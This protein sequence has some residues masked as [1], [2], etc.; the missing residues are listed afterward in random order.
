MSQVTVDYC[1]AGKFLLHD[2]MVQN[3]IVKCTC[4]I[5]CVNLVLCEL[6]IFLISEFAMINQL[7]I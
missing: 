7:R 4:T 3:L 2:W 5:F 1:F 6:D